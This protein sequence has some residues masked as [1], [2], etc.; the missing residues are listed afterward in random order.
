[1]Q[2]GVLS[3]V[4]L[5]SQDIVTGI[6]QNVK[7]PGETWLSKVC[8]DINRR[9]VI[10]SKGFINEALNHFHTQ[11]TQAIWGKAKR[12][13]LKT[14]ADLGDTSTFKYKF[15]QNIFLVYHVTC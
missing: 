13:I 2:R 10:V 15:N 1:M 6:E 12:N 5:Q 11:Q 9:P 3:D 14:E 7:E 4:V 8:F